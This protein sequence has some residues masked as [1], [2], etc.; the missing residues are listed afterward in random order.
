MFCC[1]SAI[2]LQPFGEKNE[3]TTP[4]TKTGKPMF[5]CHPFL[6]TGGGGPEVTYTIRVRFMLNK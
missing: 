3:L 1:S 6:K 4:D 2:L 5:L